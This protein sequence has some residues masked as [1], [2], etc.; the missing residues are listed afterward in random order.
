MPTSAC[1]CETSRENKALAAAASIVSS[2]LTRHAFHVHEHNVYAL[3]S[4]GNCSTRL[5]G[6]DRLQDA[7]TSIAE[8][9]S[10]RLPHE[11]VALHHQNRC[12]FH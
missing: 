10:K 9:L 4:G 7:I 11:N 1:A 8:I 5:G 3:S 6:I 2:A 12:R